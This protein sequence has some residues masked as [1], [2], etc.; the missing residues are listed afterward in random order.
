MIRTTWTRSWAFWLALTVAS[1]AFAAEPQQASTQPRHASVEIDTSDVGEEGPVIKRRTRERADVVLRAAGVL[2]GRTDAGDP[3]IFVDVD[4]LEGPEPGYQCEV[5][6]SYEG[7]V[8]GERRRVECPLCTESEIVQRV[9]TTMSELIT[10]LP[11]EGDVEPTDSSPTDVTPPTDTETDGS[12]TTTTT[13]TDDD[14]PK[15]LGGMGKAGIALIAVGVAGA[16][17][18]AVMVALPAKVDPDDP[19]FETT[20]RPP[21]IATMAAGGATLVTGIVL[22][23]IDRR[24]ARTRTTALVPMLSPTTAGLSWSGRF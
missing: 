18:G 20:Y 7:K 4:E 17:A 5:W 21:G 10:L 14:R 9:E 15:G 11:T 19:L 12:T 6:I 13:P 23:V 24:R 3:V 2:P 16:A 22:L 1:P 8:L